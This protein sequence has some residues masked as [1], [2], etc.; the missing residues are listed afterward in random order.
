MTNSRR[1]ILWAAHG[2]LVGLCWGCRARVA[3]AQ[4]MTPAE[5]PAVARSFARILAWADAN[6]PLLR[7]SLRPGASEDQ[8][9]HFEGLIGQALPEDVRELYRLAD[10]QIPY[11]FGETYYPGLF[12]GFPFNP[13]EVTTRDWRNH[14]SGLR[15]ID[16]NT[17]EFLGSYPPDA[18]K[19]VHF[20][21]GW[22]ALSDDASGNYMGVDLD[23]AS[24]GNVG[25]WIVFGRDESERLRVASSLAAFL[26][27]VAGEMEAG[28]FRPAQAEPWVQSPRDVA[29]LRAG[30]PVAV[31][32]PP[33]PDE[34][35][36][37][38]GYLFHE[39]RLHLKSGGQIG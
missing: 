27:W 20:N 17:D 33:S 29:A 5:A 32:D 22:I 28:N 11:Q 15:G 18:V 19:A 16:S 4:P 35:R 36:W 30:R 1:E 10:G 37:R 31:P 6:A 14:D 2:A 23:P 26:H 9:R 24:A 7:E 34:W 38:N 25:Q 3:A 39:L 12:L 8:L 13:I 21:N